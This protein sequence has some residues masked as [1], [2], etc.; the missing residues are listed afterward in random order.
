MYLCIKVCI[1]YTATIKRW[2]SLFYEISLHFYQNYTYPY[3]TYRNF[4]D[5]CE[6]YLHSNHQ[7]YY[8]VSFSK[9]FLTFPRVAA[10]KIMINIVGFKL[11]TIDRN[12]TKTKYKTKSSFQ[13]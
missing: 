13:L 2:T 3:Y 4:F 10:L 1:N 11:R 8:P 9:S 12:K 6:N 5:I 7:S